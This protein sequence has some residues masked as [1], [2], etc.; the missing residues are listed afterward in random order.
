MRSGSFGPRPGVRRAM[1]IRLR[2]AWFPAA[3]RLRTTTRLLATT[4]LL[5]A[6]VSL[7]GLAPVCCAQEPI[8]VE[9][10]QVVV[11]TAVFDK[12]LYGHKHDL[13]AQI[14]NDPNFWDTIAIKDLVASDFHLSEDGKEQ[15]IVSAK[16]EAATAIMVRDNRGQHL[17]SVGT[18][19]GR[20]SHPDTQ[21]LSWGFPHYLV[22]YW[23]PY[24]RPG[25]CHEVMVTVSRPNLE[26]FARSEYCNTK[27]P[28]TDPLNGTAFGEK[29]DKDLAQRGNGKLAMTARAWPF[30]GAAGESRVYLTLQY[31]P[32]ELKHE[33]HG[34]KLYASIG[35]LGK[36]YAKDGKLVQRF[37]D[38]ACC[39]Y[40]N[41]KHSF[42]T[43][44]TL[45]IPDERSTTLV[46]NR[47]DTQIDLP[48]GDYTLEVVLSDGE[49]FGRRKI[50]LHVPELKANEL[51][52]SDVA[53][54]GRVRTRPTIAP[55]ALEVK[56]GRY[57]PLISKNA[58][59]VPDA[60]AVVT[61]Y[62]NADVP[63]L[64]FYFEI[65]APRI[66][67]TPP[68]TSLEA[69]MRVVDSRSGA[70]KID[71]GAVDALAYQTVDS[72]FIFIGRGMRL[73]GLGLGSY[74][75]EVQVTDSNGH[76]SRLK[77]APFAI[78]LSPFTTLEAVPRQ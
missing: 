49:N 5:L 11:P 47:Y 38:F 53:L 12:K 56:A 63:S 68:I 33:L 44:L 67:G 6:C 7:A 65:Y 69:R 2:S 58:E 4:S 51:S 25:S 21:Y 10:D 24:S 42:W 74:Q 61:Q 35:L 50:P 64:Y 32:G 78:E 55:D 29:M 3:V 36:I 16:L 45:D 37:S 34:D 39:D 28:A 30:H 57:I 8:R 19:G 17:E 75:L 76:S 48:P 71:L 41:Q 18:G 77:V 46:P 52:I 13:S 59:F 54:C 60:D 72:P 73:D 40:G 14:A 70:I 66:E 22:S 26:V 43:T 27:H 23:P 62:A 20:W 31:P 9:T 15:S 1:L